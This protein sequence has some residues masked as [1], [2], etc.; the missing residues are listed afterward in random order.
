MKLLVEGAAELPL[1]P[2]CLWQAAFRRPSGWRLPEAWSTSRVVG[3]CQTWSWKGE[4]G[5]GGET[6]PGSRAGSP[7]LSER[8]VPELSQTG[9]GPCTS[10]SHRPRRGPGPLGRGMGLR[11]AQ[12]FAYG[13]TAKLRTAPGSC[14]GMRLWVNIVPE[15]GW[16]PHRPL[17]P[18][19]WGARFPGKHQLTVLL[20]RAQCLNPLQPPAG[21]VGGEGICT[22]AVRKRREA[23]WRC[24]ALILFA[25]P[26]LCVRG[27]FRNPTS[28]SGPAGRTVGGRGQWNV[29]SR[30]FPVSENRG[31]CACPSHQVMLVPRGERGGSGGHAAQ[32]HG[33]CPLSPRA[34]GKLTGEPQLWPR[35]LGTCWKKPG[36]LRA[37]RGGWGGAGLKTPVAQG[38]GPRTDSQG[39]PPQ[40]R[41]SAGGSVGSTLRG[42]GPGLGAP[43]AAWQTGSSASAEMNSV[44]TSRFRV[45]PLPDPQPGRRRQERGAADAGFT[46]T[47]GS[48]GGAV[49]A[50]DANATKTALRGKPPPCRVYKHLEKGKNTASHQINNANQLH[51]RPPGTCVAPARTARTAR[52]PAPAPPACRRRHD[53]R[54]QQRDGGHHGPGSPRLGVAWGLW[55]A[56][57]GSRDWF[58][59]KQEISPRLSGRG[60]RGRHPGAL[61]PEHFPGTALRLWTESW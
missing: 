4:K 24:G 23:G 3:S 12:G 28:A 8:R 29:P 22:E 25:L 26:A 18:G 33:T 14:W 16:E 13:L 19:L 1:P 2:A 44:L 27:K 55:A 52:T 5:E 32:A 50:Q 36:M 58:W 10:C 20:G 7:P 34:S 17:L 41:R 9:C 47:C 43:S 30:G 21:V 49:L 42:S 48:S 53:H 45:H 31:P 6:L 38:L 61:L 40:G 11:Q 57:C 35:S 54:Q 59:K 56:A 15:L 39:H 46:S 51:A 37:G 60:E